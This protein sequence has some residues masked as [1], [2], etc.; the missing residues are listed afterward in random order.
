MIK[1]TDKIAIRATDH[2][3]TYK[4]MLC[5]AHCFASHVTDYKGGR[6]I[7]LSENRPAWA[8]A[9]F[10][11]WQAGA[12]AVPVDAA[13]TATDIAYVIDDCTPEAIFVSKTNR[14]LSMKPLRWPH[15]SHASSTLTR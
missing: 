8:Y 7:I 13:S 4:Q 2:Q 12:T 3:V 6:V 1:A 5:Y 10:G 14:R 9:I 11:I 15:I